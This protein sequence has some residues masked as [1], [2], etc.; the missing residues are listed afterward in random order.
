MIKHV[1]SF[2]QGKIKFNN[3]LRKNPDLDDVIKVFKN[4]NVD[5]EIIANIWRSL[6]WMRWIFLIA[7]SIPGLLYSVIFLTDLK[8]FA[9]E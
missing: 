5:P 6:Y 8:S 1:H 3:V 9:S 4:S 7:L 2:N